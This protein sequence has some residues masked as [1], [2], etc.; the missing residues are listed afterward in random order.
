M[1]KV[2]V[3]FDFTVA[4]QNFSPHISNSPEYVVLPFWFEAVQ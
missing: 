2:F 4:Y 1:G 3:Q